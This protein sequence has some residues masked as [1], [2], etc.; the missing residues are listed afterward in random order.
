MSINFGREICGVLDLAAGREWLVTNGIGGYASG[1]VAGILTRRYHGLLVAALKPPL[2]RTLLLAKLDETALYD[3]RNY[4]LGAN[5]WHGGA[6]NPDGYRHIESFELEGTIPRWRFAC[7]D[8]SL[9]KR[10]WMQADSNTTYLQYHLHRATQPLVLKLKALVN[11]RDYHGNTHTQDWQMSIDAVEQGIRVTAFEGAVPLYLLS[12][13]THISPAHQWYYEFDLARERDRG[14]DDREDHLHA[15][16]FE[17]TLQPG[18]SLTFVASTEIYPD[19]NG[20]AAL[21]LRH[22]YDQKLLGIWKDNHVNPK[23]TPEWIHQLVLATD[24]FIVSR[25]LPDQPDGKT[26]I[27]GYHWFSDWGRD[28]MISLPGLTISVGRPELARPILRTF[29][30]YVNQGMLPNRFPDAG[31]APEYNTVDATLWYFEAIR[32]YYAATKDEELLSELFPVLADIINWHRQGTRYNIHLDPNDGLLYAGETGVQL[33]W[34]DAKVGDWVVTPRIG[35]PIEVNALWCNALATMAN[36]ARQ[37]GK[38]H[39]EYEQM[40]KHAN[41]GF[42][43]FWNEAVGYCYDVLDGPEGHDQSL[44]PNQ[45]FAVSLPESP[46][47]PVQQ[48]AVVESCARSLLTSGGLRSLDPKHPQYQGNYGGD[49]LQ[50]DSAYHQGTVWGW[51]I[52]PFVLAHLRVFNHPAQARSF[53]KPMAN[54]LCAHGVGSLSEIFDG[55]EPFTPRGCIAQA[56]TVAEV[57]RAWVAT[58]NI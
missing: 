37:L 24:Q 10:V 57:L 1:T 12:D 23:T 43:R 39:Q 34:M 31:E 44:R 9:E 35:K 20:K 18:E 6:I 2:M 48:R 21:D 58:E 25:P 7:A 40:Q 54:H 30:R 41:S 55:N 19:L 17:A 27:A 38:P 8:A 16:T 28:T 26:I 46:L 50:R 14:L 53:L 32:A 11:Y 36:F 29:A 5:R 52:G 51:L 33:T 3:G 45:I 47:T 56:W 42:Q 15:A 4:S 13:R 22:S 49:Q